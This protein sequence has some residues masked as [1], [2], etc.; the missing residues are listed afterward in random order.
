V[1]AIFPRKPAAD[2]LLLLL[3]GLL[4]A[5]V[6]AACGKKGPPLAPLL[7]APARVT[8]FEARRVDETVYVQVVIPAT[9]EDG[10]QP[11]DLDYV[12]VYAFTGMN[13]GAVLDTKYAE[14]IGTIKVQ[15]PMSP[16]EQEKWT[17][18]GQTPPARPGEP[19]GGT[20]VLTEQLTPAAKVIIQTKEPKE[21]VFVAK[22]NVGELVTPPLV[23]PVE[24]PQPKRYYTARG[25][26]H[27]KVRGATAPRRPIGLGVPPPS[28]RSPALDY[29]E[30]AFALTWQAPAEQRALIQE[31]A[32]GDVLPAA[33]KGIPAGVVYAYNVYRTPKPSETGTAAALPTLLSRVPLN[34]KPLEVLAFEDPGLVF[35]EERCYVIRSVES[36]V[37]SVA[38]APVCATPVDHFPPP[39]PAALTAVASEGGISLIWDGVTAS[40]L[41]GYVVLRGEVPNGAFVPLFDAPI[42]ETAYRDSTAK[43]GVRYAYVVVS[44]D[45]AAP[46]NLSAPSNRVEDSAR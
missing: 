37:E 43:P 38:T 31:P 25:F 19:Q 46:R 14:R 1:N 23:G 3:T 32:T 20:V 9:N 27:G 45:T 15:D 5:G 8:D 10:T 33:P 11:A 29:A 4:A 18:R 16:E 44:V 39:V 35:G 17:S 12:E 26:S 21:K 6:T 30:Q 41:A 22:R 2:L 7:K 40:D 36:A 13:A 28:P 24:E 42:R 34:P